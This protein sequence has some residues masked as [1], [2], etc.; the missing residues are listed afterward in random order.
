MHSVFLFFYHLKTNF[1]HIKYKI[2]TNFIY[3][4]NERNLEMYIFKNAI[5]SIARS[6]G[7]NVLIGIIVLVIATASCIGLSIRNAA[8]KAKAAALEG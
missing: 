7:R 3:T 2:L 1:C 5:R 8:S 4:K 6:K